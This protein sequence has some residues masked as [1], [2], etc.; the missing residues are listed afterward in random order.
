MRQLPPTEFKFG[1]Y[2]SSLIPHKI[3]LAGTKEFAKWLETQEVIGYC[4]SEDV[5]IRPRP[6]NYCVMIKED[7]WKG[8]SH[9]PDFVFDRYLKAME[10]K[11]V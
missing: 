8:W 11:N 9:I 1:N 7:D 2:D 5:E 3:F 10:N 6:E 4:K